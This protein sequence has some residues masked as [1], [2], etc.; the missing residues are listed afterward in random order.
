MMSVQEAKKFD[1]ELD[2]KRAEHLG[3]FDILA[4]HAQDSRLPARRDI[5]PRCEVLSSI[6]LVTVE[7]GGAAEPLFGID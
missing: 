7:H 6:S 4:E 3:V 5:G 2:L 1:T